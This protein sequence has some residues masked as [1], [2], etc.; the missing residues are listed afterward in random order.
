MVELQTSYMGK[1]VSKKGLGNRL[2][3]YCWSRE[4]AEKK[5]FYFK[6][7]SIPGF[8]ETY[9]DILGV[10]FFENEYVTPGPT[11]IFD[12]DKIYIIKT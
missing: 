7:D 1:D 5:G 6:T 3:Q 9:D 4:I 11:Q 10:K 8:P 12:M 2:F